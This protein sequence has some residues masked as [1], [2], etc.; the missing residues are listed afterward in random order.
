MDIERWTIE[1]DELAFALAAPIW[2]R[3][4]TFAGHPLIRGVVT[5]TVEDQLVVISG[6]RGGVRFE[7]FVR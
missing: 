2:D 5:W 1:R 6:E 4:G 3:F 7:E